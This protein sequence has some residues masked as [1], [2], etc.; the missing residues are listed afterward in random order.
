MILAPYHLSTDDIERLI[1]RTGVVVSALGQ[2]VDHPEADV[3]YGNDDSATTETVRWL[4]REKKHERIGLIGVTDN[5]DAGYRRR[6]AFQD[7]LDQAGVQ[8][9]PGYFQEGDW[10]IESGRAAMKALLAQRV[11]PTAVLALNDLMA[12]GAMDAIVRHGLHI[13]DDIAVVGFDD[14]P[15]SS[16]VCPKL[17]TI[18]QFPRQM[19]E[20]LAAAV[21]ERLDGYNGAGRRRKVCLRLIEREST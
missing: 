13:P 8:M 21:F 5:F 4:I 7:A 10:S 15:A 16:W 19:G 11:L 14:I 17:T 6:R 18:A 9:A 3:V 1:D 2:H 20:A 12:I